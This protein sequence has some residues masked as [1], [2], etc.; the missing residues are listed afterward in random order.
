M[1]SRDRQSCSV[2]RRGNRVPIV[3][4][5]DQTGV[6]SEGNQN[7]AGCRGREAGRNHLCDSG[8]TRGVFS[9]R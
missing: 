8:S 9:A 5:D 7:G 6:R 1:R 2:K 3:V 4:I